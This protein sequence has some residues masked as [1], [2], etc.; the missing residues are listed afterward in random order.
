MKYSITSGFLGF[1][2]VRLKLTFSLKYE[3]QNRYK[4][5]KKK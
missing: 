1:E 2:Q 5:S 4:F 3:C